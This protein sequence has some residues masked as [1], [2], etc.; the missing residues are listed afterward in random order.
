MGIQEVQGLLIG[1]Q[2]TTKGHK[3]EH[4]GT[5]GNSPVALLLRIVLVHQLLEMVPDTLSLENLGSRP[6]NCFL[7]IYSVH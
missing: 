5:A 3:S 2:L 4:T 6:T 1:S 7:V